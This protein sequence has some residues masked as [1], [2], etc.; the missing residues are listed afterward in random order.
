MKLEV[1]NLDISNI[2]NKLLRCAIMDTGTIMRNLRIEKD[3]TLDEL[4]NELNN[5]YNLKLNKGMISKWEA[6]K[7]EPRFEYV[8]RYAD[9]FDVSLD[10][11]LGLTEKRER[12]NSNR[13]NSEEEKK[14]KSAPE[15]VQ[16]LIK[17]H[18]LAAYGGYNLD[19]MTEEEIVEFANELLRQIE[20][21]SYKYK[22]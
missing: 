22:K 2:N 14:L 15:A 9:Y 11:L 20:L 10:Y 7:I 8:K 17:N 6:G 21:I 13:N 5:R 4:A 18:S 1:Y 3:L 16:Y 12:I 19:E